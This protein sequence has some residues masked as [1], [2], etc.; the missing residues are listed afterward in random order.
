[1]VPLL[2]D[3]TDHSTEIKETLN[4]FG[5]NS[6]PLLVI[7]PAGRP[8]EHVTIPDLVSKTQV[9]DALKKA[10]PSQATA[11]AAPRVSVR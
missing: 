9:L 3:W 7:F 2:A 8:N 4:K 1:M 6:I 11:A 10:G 5:H